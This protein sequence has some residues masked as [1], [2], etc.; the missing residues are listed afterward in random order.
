MVATFLSDPSVVLFTTLLRDLAFVVHAG[1]ILTFAL[2]AA[3]SHR[4]GGPPRHRI[5]RVYQAFGPGLGISLGLL[6]FSSLVLHYATVG[7]FDWSPAGGGGS[8]AGTAAWVVFF[9]AWVSNI[10]L[11][12]WTLEP[13]RKLDP[14]GT[15]TASDA[16]ALERSSG[17]VV[18][19]LIV[20]A[21]LWATVLVLAR[22]TAGT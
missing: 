3:L 14:D 4:V 19:H 6:V 12:V 18:R 20:Q 22:I 7:A 8:V 10:K 15:G 16:A 2:L 5:L 13:L 21:G 1:G 11:E 9:V 17:K